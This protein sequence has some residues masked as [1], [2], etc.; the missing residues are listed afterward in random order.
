V[1]ERCFPSTSTV[2]TG[3]GKEQSLGETQGGGKR[4]LF[5][6][7]T[8]SF[9]M[10][11][12]VL[13]LSRELSIRQSW[14][15]GERSRSGACVLAR[16]LQRVVSALNS[17]HTLHAVDDG[18]QLLGGLCSSKSRALLLLIRGAASNATKRI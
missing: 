6:H 14:P 12:L 7:L 3:S 2:S 18:T 11:N 5:A 15:F 1:S 17:E 4:G 10:G 9:E 13:P 8:G 16:R